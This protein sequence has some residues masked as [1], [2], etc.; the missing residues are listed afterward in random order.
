MLWLFNFPT[1]PGPTFSPFPFPLSPFPFPLSHFPFPLSPFPKYTNKLSAQ[2][3]KI[4]I[5]LKL[6]HTL[7]SATGVQLLSKQG[8]LCFLW[9]LFSLGGGEGGWKAPDSGGGGV[10]GGWV[11]GFPVKN[12]VWTMAGEG[13]I[14]PLDPPPVHKNIKHLRGQTAHTTSLIR[15]QTSD[16]IH[17]AGL[18]GP[19]Q[20][21][22]HPPND[23][24][25]VQAIAVAAPG[26][27]AARGHPGL[28]QGHLGIRPP[29]TRDGPGGACAPNGGHRGLEPS[30]GPVV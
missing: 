18:L 25:A 30:R 28:H 20:R 27:L 3:T 1:F 6:S 19:F 10:G 29:P 13:G 17:I 15:H 4:R 23:A 8:G 12:L 5:K 9:R 26:S 2:T 22:L 11:G 24:H 21:S 7:L 14:G 16:L